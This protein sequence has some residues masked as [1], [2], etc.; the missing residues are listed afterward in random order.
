MQL[1]YYPHAPYSRKVL[2]AA[3]E[4]AVAFDR[5]I[6]PPFGPA[7]AALTALHPFATV[8]LL[9]D[10]AEILTESSIIVEAFDLASGSGPALVPPDP[11]LALRARAL[12]RLSDAHVMAPTAY[13]AWALRKPEE[14]RN[15]Q[16]IDAQRAA[17]LV[18]LDVLDAA[19]GEH[20]FV[21]GAALTLADLSPAAA[22]SCLLA[23]RTLADLAAFPRVKRW[24][25]AMITRPSFSTI[26]AECRD[27]PL[28]PGF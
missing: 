21:A 11:R 20:A 27:V 28:P 3:Y 18:A 2:L 5:K 12:D 6:C 24:Y 10:G 22:I 25:G 7:K 13:L 4:K 1:H 16:K 17:L 19:I 23:D 26:F 14:T 15:H 8:P 9:V